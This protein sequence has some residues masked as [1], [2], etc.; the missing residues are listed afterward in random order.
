MH[1]S[2]KDVL[3]SGSE[4]QRKELLEKLNLTEDQI[5]E[6]DL[7][8]GVHIVSTTMEA[9]GPFEIAP[10]DAKLQAK[11]IAL[12]RTPSGGVFVQLA[13]GVHVPKPIPAKAPEPPKPEPTAEEQALAYLGE[14]GLSKAEAEAAIERFGVS[15]ILAK[16]NQARNEE[17]DALLA[18]SK[19]TA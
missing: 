19:P 14:K 16:R 6:H 9:D 17:L 2:T 18:P 7:D 15:Q 4:K 5:D 3:V 1:T 10:A 13:V 8:D 11:V 12:R